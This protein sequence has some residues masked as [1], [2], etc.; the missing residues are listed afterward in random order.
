MQYRTLGTDLTVSSVGLG[1]MGMSHAYGAPADKKEMTELLAQAVDMGY[2]FFDTAEVYGTTDH[3]HANE[4]LIGAALKPY[5][6]KIILATKFGI[7]FDST[8]KEVNKPLIPDSRPEVIRTSVEASL[9]RLQT[10]HID[11][12]YQHRLDPKIPIEEVAGVMSDLIREGKI[13][14]WGLSE[15]TEDSIRRAHAVC[16]VT[17]IQNRY[18]MMARWHENLFPVLEQLHIGYV[19]FSPLANGFLSGRYGKNANFDKKYDYRSNMPQFQSDGIDQN[20]ELLALLHQ[21]AQEKQATPAQ[22]S[23]AWMLCKKP[24]I[25]PIPGT[26]KLSRL[27]ENAGAA[28]VMLS[29]KEVAAIDKALDGMKMSQVFGGSRIVKQ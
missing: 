15:A 12:Y 3:P 7:H 29:A 10:D 18:S 23:L 21:L 9:Q 26:R 1:C 24:Y 17:A 8:S 25:V 5:R 28:D 14:H 27:A 13:T 19:A 11:L 22:I 2:T 20:Q 6:E 4:E 16:P